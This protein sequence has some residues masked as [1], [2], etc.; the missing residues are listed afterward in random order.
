MK[1]G[2]N[3][4]MNLPASGNS[5]ECNQSQHADMSFSVNCYLLIDGVFLMLSL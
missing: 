4:L 1:C 3:E 5:S 2:M